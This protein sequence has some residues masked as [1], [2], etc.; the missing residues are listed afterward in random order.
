LA[1]IGRNG[2][3]VG[4]AINV[5]VGVNVGVSDGV[6]VLVTAGVVGVGVNVTAAVI[7][8]LRLS[9]FEQLTQPPAEQ[10]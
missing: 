8:K 9:L 10:S 6:G 7:S 1:V 2:A 3:L 5:T 4:V